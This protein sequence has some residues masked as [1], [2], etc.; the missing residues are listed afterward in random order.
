MK[1]WK[2]YAEV[3]INF[4]IEF[5]KTILIKS[6]CKETLKMQLKSRKSVN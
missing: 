5:T 2:I 4:N 1:A 6:D 3:D